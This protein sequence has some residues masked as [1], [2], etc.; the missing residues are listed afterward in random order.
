MTVIRIGPFDVRFIDGRYQ[1]R[2]A[3]RGGWQDDVRT[4]DEYRALVALAEPGKG[5]AA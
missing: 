2:V 5:R 1:W 4:P 3:G